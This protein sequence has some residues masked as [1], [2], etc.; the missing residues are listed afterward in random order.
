MD[1]AMVA[2]HIVVTDKISIRFKG[3][4]NKMIRKVLAH[5][6]CFLKCVFL[7]IFSTKFIIS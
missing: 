3:S 4:T 2:Y 7:E 1:T 5:E 6:V